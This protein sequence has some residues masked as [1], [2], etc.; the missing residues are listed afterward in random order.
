MSMRSSFIYGYGFN[1]DCDDGALVDFIKEHKDT[2]CKTEKEKELYNDI[3]N[4]NYL[5]DLF[6]HYS[7][8]NTGMEG[9]GSVIANIMS[10]ET[11]IRFV[12]CPPDD[13]CNTFASVVFEQGY[14]WQLNESEKELTE[15][16]LSNIC[17]KYMDELRITDV[18]DYL[19]LEYYG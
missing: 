9:I 7:C 10:R 3:F 2:F 14:P 4:Y 15:E 1:C 16:K 13:E 17:K 18:P 12:Y 5:E 19:A 11:G 8:D 6:E